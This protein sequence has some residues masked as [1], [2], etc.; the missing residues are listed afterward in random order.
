MK[1]FDLRFKD[2]G[3]SFNSCFQF[4]A[5]TSDGELII[6]IKIYWKTLA[7]LQS[8]GVLKQLG[9]NTRALFYPSIRMGQALTE[10]RDA[11]LMRIEI[12]YTA[13]TRAKENWLLH[14]LFPQ[15][16]KQHISKVAQALSR[17]KG[18]CWR[19]PLT[20]LIDT[21]TEQ[22]RANQLLVVQSNSAALIYASNQKSGCFTGFF[23]PGPARQS[24]DFLSFLK[25]YALPGPA[26]IIHCIL[27]NHGPT[28]PTSFYTIVKEGPLA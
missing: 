2:N 13:D 9:M 28:G 25:I 4:V 23:Q 10:S 6:R 8:D 21:F 14:R 19:L 3:N 1:L 11:G 20:K 27:Q 5:Q 26:S 18:I 24:F 15:E 7:L 17:V 12:T 16:A 22:P